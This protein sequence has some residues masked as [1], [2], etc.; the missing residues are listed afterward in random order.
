MSVWFPH[1]DPIS[2]P[3]SLR[4]PPLPFPLDCRGFS[5]LTIQLHVPEGHWALPKGTEPPPRADNFFLHS[6]TKPAEKLYI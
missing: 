2:R 1:L 3:L 6:H 4:A 5:R